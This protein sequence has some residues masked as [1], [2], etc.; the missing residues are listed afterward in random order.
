VTAEEGCCLNFLFN[1]DLG[2]IIPFDAGQTCEEKALVDISL[3][4]SLLHPL[5]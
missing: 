4:I 5:Y 1:L 2:I 3:L